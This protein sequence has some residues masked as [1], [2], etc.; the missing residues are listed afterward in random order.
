MNYPVVI[1]DPKR[2]R[3]LSFENPERIVV[4][5]RREDVLPALQDVEHEV[6]TRGLFA[7]GFLSYEAAPAFDTALTV[8]SDD[9]GFP[10]LWFLSLIHI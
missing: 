3:W 6:N 10:L 2:N 9:S 4:A 1:H 7:A 5:H 8:R